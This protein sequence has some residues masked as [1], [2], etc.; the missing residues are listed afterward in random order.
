MSFLISFAFTHCT[1]KK[2]ERRKRKERTQRAEREKK[3]EREKRKKN[4]KRKKKEERKNA[5]INA[6][7]YVTF[8]ML[9]LDIL[10]KSLG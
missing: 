6:K 7:V 3:A 2:E 1:N 8:Y 10:A 5:E 4:T 9:P